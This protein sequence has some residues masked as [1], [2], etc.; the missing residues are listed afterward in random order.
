[1]SLL[2]SQASYNQE[3]DKIFVPGGSF[4]MGNDSGESQEIPSNKKR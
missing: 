3:F 2:I 4:F 1:M